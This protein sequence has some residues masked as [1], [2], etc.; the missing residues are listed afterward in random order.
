MT[1]ELRLPSKTI[2]KVFVAGVAEALGTQAALEGGRRARRAYR[3][4]APWP[5]YRLSA[6][7]LRAGHWVGSA[8]HVS[9]GCLV[10]RNTKPT[11]TAFVGLGRPKY[12]PAFL[13]L[14][15]VDAKRIAQI[16]SDLDRRKSVQTNT[17]ELRGLTS[18]VLTLSAI[19]LKNLRDDDYLIYP[20]RPLPVAKAPE[21]S[22]QERLRWIATAEAAHKLEEATCELE[23]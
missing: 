16:L 20:I 12:P 11:W 8:K 14:G 1:I 4:V 18:P 22:A 17:Y 23:G 15:H 19:W 10:L 2:T 21:H 5:M 13:D 6:A 7:Q 3:L 9:W